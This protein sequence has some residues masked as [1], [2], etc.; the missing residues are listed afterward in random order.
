ML[1]PIQV[2]RD[3]V[4]GF[5]AIGRVTGE[6]YEKILVPAMEEA[7]KAHGKI[8]FLYEFGPEFESFNPR[9]LWDD[10]KVGF[11]HLR[12]FERIAVVS[13]IE[14]ITHGVKLFEFAI[15]YPVRV[16]P[17]A[18]REAALAWIAED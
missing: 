2:T 1:E 16:F 12:D 7:I 10:A 4:L 9:A 8:R 15:P 17:T 13:D 11:R 6:D 14:W 3:D 5:K 18:E